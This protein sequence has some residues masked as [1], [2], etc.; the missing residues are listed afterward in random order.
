MHG[1]PTK[2]NAP[3]EAV[4]GRYF[5]R[6][7][8]FKF[9]STMILIIFLVHLRF[10]PTNENEVKK[11]KR[12][13]RYVNFTPIGWKMK[14]SK[15]CVQTTNTGE[16]LPRKDG[17]TYF[18]FDHV[19]G[20]QATNKEVY[21][22]TTAHIV[23]DFVKGV[24]GSVICYGQ[25]GS[26]KSYTVQGKG[27]INEG[28]AG[29][30]GLLHLSIQSI[31]QEIATFPESYF[32][33]RVSVIEVYNEEIRDLLDPEFDKDKKVYTVYDSKGGLSIDSTEEFVKNVD[34]VYKVLTLVDEHKVVK[35]TDMNAKSSRSHVV[36]KFVLEK[37]EDDESKVGAVQV[38]TFNL[39]DLAG[40]DT[41][42]R[43]LLKKSSSEENEIKKEG[44]SINKR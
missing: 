9:L 23:K 27:T 17:R 11:E 15:T 5:C 20:E 25:T 41:N 28:I 12:G 30:Y 32:L 19:F 14:D 35:K 37:K 24:S 10:R 40:S 39:V 13:R 44:S 2:S 42:K 8:D 21:D 16:P 6:K 31:F 36:Y 3:V 34:D 43:K 29:G 38:S 7:L 33:L 1:S 4:K 18:K 26:G 22:V